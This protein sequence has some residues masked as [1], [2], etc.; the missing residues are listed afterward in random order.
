MTRP[1]QQLRATYNPQ[2]AVKGTRVD[3]F[4]WER[5]PVA[6]VTV[7]VTDFLIWVRRKVVRTK[8]LSRLERGQG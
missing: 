3:R 4:D 5:E 6:F 2:P 1:P 7:V 8:S